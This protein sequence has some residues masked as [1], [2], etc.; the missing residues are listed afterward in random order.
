MT[1]DEILSKMDPRPKY[2]LQYE[3]LINRFARVL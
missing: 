1:V 3:G 2:D